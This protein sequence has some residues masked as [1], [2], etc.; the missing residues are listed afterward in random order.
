MSGVLPA[1]GRGERFAVP[2][3]AYKK[4]G[5]LHSGPGKIHNYKTKDNHYEH[6]TNKGRITAAPVPVLPLVYV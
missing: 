3:F 2:L 6:S 1:F 4:P 5:T